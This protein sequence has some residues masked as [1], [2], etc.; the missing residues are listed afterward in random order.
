MVT[1]LE[2]LSGV[3]VAS[4]TGDR[5]ELQLTTRVNPNHPPQTGLSAT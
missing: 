3:S 2:A 4:V 1:T 5:L